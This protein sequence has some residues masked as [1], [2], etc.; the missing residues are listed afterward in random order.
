MKRVLVCLVLVLRIFAISYN[1]APKRLNSFEKKIVVCIFAC[2]DE[3]YLERNLDSIFKQDYSNYRVLYVDDASVDDTFLRVFNYVKNNS[4]EERVKLY[5]NDK[6]LGAMSNFYSMAHKC[7]DEEIVI[8]VRGCDWFATNNDFKRINQAYLD[9]NVWATYGSCQ[10][11]PNKS[12]CL[13]RVLRLDLLEKRMHRGLPFAMHQ[14]YT[15]Y[16]SLFKKIPKESFLDRNGEFYSQ[17][18]SLALIVSLIDV[19]GNHA[20]CI[21]EIGYTVNVEKSFKDD[22]RL[23]Q[24]RQIRKNPILDKIEKLEL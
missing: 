5:Q 11:Y 17:A 3:Q 14:V 9:S 10:V 4:L 24:E 13:G 15:C 19:A 22:R 12:I 23:C 2:N 7:D 6:T 16:G 1:Y 18:W 20:Y 8:F 21:P